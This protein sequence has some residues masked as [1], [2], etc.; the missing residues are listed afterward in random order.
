MPNFA[1]LNNVDHRNMRVIRDYSSQY[2]DNEISV[3]TFPQE[4]RAIQNEYPIFL[5]KNAETGKFIPVALMGLRQN[6]NVFLSEAGWDAQYIP[7]SVK[8]RPF[9]IGVQPPKPGEGEQPSRL[10][11]V[12]MDS[13]RLSEVAGD[14][15]FLPHG[16]YSPYLETMVELLEYIQYGTEL[17]EQFVDMLLAS[18]LLEV[19]ALEITLKSGEQNNLA[20]LYTINE[21]KLNGLGG[22]AV[23]ELHAKG[24][25]ECIYMILASHAN[26]LKLIA[27]VE[28]R[29]SAQ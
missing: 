1:L 24:F 2:G 21:D 17:N 12:D 28:A 13:P 27:R 23:A 16:G 18:E 9:L 26:V 10:V 19:V 25:L 4:F 14:P 5:K 20:G 6:E 7:A 8:R 3:V 22:S 29:L 15:V 11:Y